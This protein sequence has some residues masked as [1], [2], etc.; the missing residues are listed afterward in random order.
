MVQIEQ[1]F[2]I[3][4]CD[5]PAF[6]VAGFYCLEHVNFSDFLKSKQFWKYIDEYNEYND[7]DEEE[8]LNPQNMPQLKHIH[9]VIEKAYPDEPDCDCEIFVRCPTTSTG[10]IAV[11]VLDVT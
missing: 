9:W 5:D 10:A 1:I 11:T 8:R 2:I 3:D 6:K 7:L 4:S